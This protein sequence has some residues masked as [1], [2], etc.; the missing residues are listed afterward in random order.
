MVSHVVS[1]GSRGY[2]PLRV[3]LPH[4]ATHIR[5]IAEILDRFMAKI[6][7][8]PLGDSDIEI[9]FDRPIFTASKIGKSINQIETQKSY[10]RADI[11][12]SER[13]ISI[14]FTQPLAGAR[15]RFELRVSCEP[16]V[17]HLSSMALICKGL[18]GSALLLNVEHLYL[19]AK[20]PPSS[21]QDDSE[22]KEW[23]EIILPFRSTKWV[24]VTG[25]HSTNIMLAL[26]LSN[27]WRETLLP[28][29]HKLCI[30][31]P[32]RHHLPLREAVSSFTHSRQLSGSLIG[33]EYERLSSDEPHGA[34]MVCTQCLL[35][36]A[37]LF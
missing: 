14:S 29:L 19:S 20:R 18:S 27:S 34:G 7:S 30:Q 8:P 28:A 32:E 22:R 9:T 17:L 15:K 4:S 6:D 36:H 5:G 21:E 16:L 33:V 24:H 1:H 11:L 10:L 12:Y 13:A 37:N 35:Q 23:L 31:E 3:H 25:D 2:L 26:Q